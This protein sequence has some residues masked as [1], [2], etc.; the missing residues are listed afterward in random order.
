M[1][2]DELA[3]LPARLGLVEAKL[4]AMELRMGYSYAQPVACATPLWVPG[5]TPREL[6]LLPA[7]AAGLTGEEMGD[8]FC[9]EERTV[10]THVSNLITKFQV[11]NRNTVAT[12]ALATGRADIA[13]IIELW[14]R[15]RPHL[16]MEA[17]R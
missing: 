9:I 10:R 8:L 13:A 3:T 17:G 5:L 1:T 12:W 7:L 2:L 16:L 11:S 14:R 4:E 6:E 15:Y